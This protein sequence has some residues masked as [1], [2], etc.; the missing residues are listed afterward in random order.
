[1]AN[2]STCS[3]PQ[4]REQADKV[5]SMLFAGLTPLIG[6]AAGFCAPD[7]AYSPGRIA[8]WV[9]A[10]LLAGFFAS[11]SL[12]MR[13]YFPGEP[14]ARLYNAIAGAWL[15]MLSI[16]FSRGN[17]LAYLTVFLVLSL[18][19]LYR[20]VWPI[21][22]VCSL[23]IVFYLGGFGLHGIGMVKSAFP[24]LDTNSLLIHLLAMLSYSTLITYLA[25]KT[26]RN[27]HDMVTLS[28]DW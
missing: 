3:L 11:G 5:F 7:I 16:Y 4:E 22:A 27:D 21:V 6:L 2:G 19:L 23:T 28:H 8:R 14:I 20:A 25:V 9:H 18:L 15:S 13:R 24:F 12:L 10:V 1:M 17:D 26:G